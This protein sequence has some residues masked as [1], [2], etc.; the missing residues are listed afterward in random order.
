VSF[1]AFFLSEAILAQHHRG[2]SLAEPG[3]LRAVVSAGLCLGATA[4][5]GVALGAII[6]HTA[7]GVVALPVLLYLR[8]CCYP[9]RHPG[10]Q[11]WANSPR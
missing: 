7:G 6:R 10:A 3:A 11:G 4:A 8:S 2:V 9:S 1:P 5:L